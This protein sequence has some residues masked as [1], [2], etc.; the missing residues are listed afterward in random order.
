MA[1]TRGK[2]LRSPISIQDQSGRNALPPTAH[3]RRKLGVCTWWWEGERASVGVVGAGRR[4]AAGCTLSVGWPLTP[5]IPW[6]PLATSAHVGEG[7]GGGSKSGGRALLLAIWPSPSLPP[8]RRR[9]GRG[10]G[11]GVEELPRCA[12]DQCWLATDQCWLAHEILDR[13]FFSQ[14]NT[15]RKIFFFCNFSCSYVKK[16]KTPVIADI[17]KLLDTFTGESFLFLLSSQGSFYKTIFS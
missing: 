3:P 6:P 7:E 15:Y 5:P 4:T 10:G 12:L 13:C 9:G 2:L 8:F 1:E 17:G 14:T 16:C 11:C